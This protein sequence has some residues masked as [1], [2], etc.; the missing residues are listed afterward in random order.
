MIK[1]ILKRKEETFELTWHDSID[2]SRIKP[3]TQVCGICFNNKGEIL[4]I[5]TTGKWHIP[6]GKPEKGES[7]EET[8]K[9][10]MDEEADVKL[11]DIEPLGYQ[12]IENIDT[13]KT[14]YQLRFVAIIS[15]IKPQTIDPA[16]G[17]IPER[18]FINP[19]A[20][21]KYCPWGNTGK[22]MIEK[23]VFLYKKER[24]KI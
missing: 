7:F 23:A 15:K 6:G 18:K 9:R 3:I 1:D 13:K 16:E 21:L 24:V 2:F 11:K 5:N 12:K 22:A 17:K 19:S 20:F 8:L 14:I 4:I 10:E